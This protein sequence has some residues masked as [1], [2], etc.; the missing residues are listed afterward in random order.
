M[1]LTE[2][3]LRKIVKSL[4]DEQYQYPL[5]TPAHEDPGTSISIDWM[6][7][8]SIPDPLYNVKTHKLHAQGLTA[9][10]SGFVNSSAR[11]EGEKLEDGMEAYAEAIGIPELEVIRQPGADLKKGNTTYELKKSK[12]KTPN[13]MLNA[14]FPKPLDSHFYIFLTKVP[15]VG[16]IKQAL[17]SY[18]PPKKDIPAAATQD[19]IDDL[20]DD[21]SDMPLF[22]E[23]N[24]EIARE[25]M[26]S[27]MQGAVSLFDDVK[28]YIV[29][30][31]ILRLFILQSAFPGGGFGEGKFFDER[32]GEMTEAGVKGATEAIKTKL[33]KLG[34]EYKIAAKIAPALTK[35]L[36]DG[37][38]PE[39]FQ[40][41][42][43]V[44]L[45][46]LKVRIRLGIEPRVTVGEET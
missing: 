35:Q 26:L 4:L 32:T 8:N 17:K 31:Q 38:P 6:V 41:G 46:L 40:D 3:K 15:T 43:D 12:T 22:K 25:D 10:I 19:E 9:L 29:N 44:K 11:G 13:L 18:V 28:I 45:G 34:I 27:S 33:D 39:S 16:A 42:F 21:Y 30:S 2:E 20:P 24:E 7:R 5:F 36:T 14:S 23:L 37:L 1:L